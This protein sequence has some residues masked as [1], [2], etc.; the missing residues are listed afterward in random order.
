[1][2]VVL[3]L[4]LI[5]LGFF[6]FGCLVGAAYQRDVMLGRLTARAYRHPAR[7]DIDR[8]PHR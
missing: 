7:I 8:G 2:I 1:M 6:G 5:C 3:I 4:T